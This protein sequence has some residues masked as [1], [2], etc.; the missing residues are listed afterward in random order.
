VRWAPCWTGGK[1]SWGR[2]D[3]NSEGRGCDGSLS[4]LKT[5]VIEERIG[6]V[7]R[8]AFSFAPRFDLIRKPM[9]LTTSALAFAL[10][11]GLVIRVRGG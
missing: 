11:S 7:I 10:W 8:G 9:R 3:V 1:I 2:A 6:W 4:L 5:E